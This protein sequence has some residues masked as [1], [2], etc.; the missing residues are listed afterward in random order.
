MIRNWEG[1]VCII[2]LVGST[3]PSQSFSDASVSWLDDKKS[4]A[5]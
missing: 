4:R 2:F 5:D 3:G 1:E